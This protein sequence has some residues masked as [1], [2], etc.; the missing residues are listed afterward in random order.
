MIRATSSIP[1]PWSHGSI[2][3]ALWRRSILYVALSKVGPPDVTNWDVGDIRNNFPAGKVVLGIDWG[4]VGPLAADVKSSVVTDKWGGAMEPGVDKYYDAKQK[5]WVEKYNQAPFLAFGGWVQSVSKT[6]KN[7]ECAL[8]FISF[9]GSQNMSAKLVV[10]PR[11]GVVAI[12]EEMWVDTRAR[13]MSPASAHVL[14]AHEATKSNAH[15]DSWCLRHGR[16][17]ATEGQEGRLVVL[18]HPLLVLL[19]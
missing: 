4:D 6:A 13:R 18:L 9:M 2:T 12:A 16:D 7:P 1:T 15:A 11:R 8:D 10:T 5:Q 14:V 3:R 17:P 19:S